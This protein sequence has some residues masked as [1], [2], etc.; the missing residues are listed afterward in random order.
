MGLISI[1]FREV[2]LERALTQGL[3][4]PFIEEASGAHLSHSPAQTSKK[5]KNEGSHCFL[6]AQKQSVQLKASQSA[7]NLVPLPQSSVVIPFQ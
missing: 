6:P 4:Q 2:L 3:E 5:K 1:C 7:A